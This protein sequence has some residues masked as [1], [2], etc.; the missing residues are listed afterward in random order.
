MKSG[1]M[2]K[3]DGFIS[4]ISRRCL[5]VML[6]ALLTVAPAAGQDHCRQGK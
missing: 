3:P 6:L 4:P 2:L 1:S 5:A